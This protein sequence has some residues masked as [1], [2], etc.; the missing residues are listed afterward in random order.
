MQYVLLL[1]TEFVAFD[2]LASAVVS[3]ASCPL[4]AWYL[5]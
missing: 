3:L 5:I 1:K 2:F 4:R